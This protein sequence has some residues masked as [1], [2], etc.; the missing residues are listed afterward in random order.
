MGNR[1]SKLR[2]T[3]A[4]LDSISKGLQE[5][6]LRNNP[7]TL[8]F[9]LPLQEPIEDKRLV[10]QGHQ[11]EPI[12]AGSKSTWEVKYLLPRPDSQEDRIARERFDEAT[13]VRRRV[14]EM[15][16]TNTCPSL[17]LLDGLEVERADIGRK[18]EVWRRLREMGVLKSLEA[19]V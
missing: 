14:Y 18:D 3:A 8:G 12:G 5:L 4:A 6:D 7:L 10:L 15:L 9:V 1:I 13:K 11:Q 19:H 17:A 16:L 2:Q